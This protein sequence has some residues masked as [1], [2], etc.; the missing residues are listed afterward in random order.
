MSL[1]VKDLVSGYG[2]IEI[3]HGVS[4]SVKEGETTAIVGPNG[5]GKSTL[6]KSI[7]GFLKI[8]QGCISFNGENITGLRPDLVLKKGISFLHQSKSVF[9]YLTVGENLKM[10]AYTIK[11]RNKINK[12]LDEIYGLFPFLEKRKNCKAINLSGG[13]Q[14]MLEIARTLMVEPKLILFD[15]PSAGLAPKLV[16]KVFKR[17]DKI[18]EKGISLLI[19][20]QNVRKVLNVSDYGYVLEMG[21][22]AFEGNSQSLLSCN[23]EMRTLYLG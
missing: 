22:N 15:E 6:L 19:V 9:P 13:Q 17:L 20:E 5:S 1:E 23:T 10:G 2:K 11:D 21:R 18:K 16:N 7:F 8:N 4:L 14:R 3:L 12:C